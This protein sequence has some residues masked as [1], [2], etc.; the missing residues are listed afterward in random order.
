MR[1]GWVQQGP[2]EQWTD[3]GLAGNPV[4]AWWSERVVHG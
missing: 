4:G 3:S 2:G 1:K